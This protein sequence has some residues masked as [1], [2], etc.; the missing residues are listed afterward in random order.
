M[1]ALDICEYSQVSGGGLRSKWKNVS[2]SVRYDKVG[3]LEGGYNL[4]KDTIGG[5]YWAGVAGRPRLCRIPDDQILQVK[6]AHSAEG[7]CP[8]LA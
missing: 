6:L 1:R 4:Y 5:A 8:S 7:I 2:Q 3:A